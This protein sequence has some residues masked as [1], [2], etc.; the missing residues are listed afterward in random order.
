MTENVYRMLTLKSFEQT[1]ELNVDELET[2]YSDSPLELKYLTQKN[3]VIIR[4]STPNTAIN[5]KD[6]QEGLLIPSLFVV[7]RLKSNCI[8]PEYLS[9]FLN[10]EHVKTLYAKY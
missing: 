4:L 10:S 3:D 1:G 2:F 5:I 6:G 9:I 8:L 7:V